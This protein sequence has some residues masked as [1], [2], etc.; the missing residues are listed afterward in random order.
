MKNIEI[1]E[2][3]KKYAFESDYESDS[4][5]NLSVGL[6]EP[7]LKLLPQWQK[8]KTLKNMNIKSDIIFGN[9]NIFATITIP[10]LFKHKNINYEDMLPEEQYKFLIY[11]IHKF[12]NQ[13]DIKEFFAYPFYIHFELHKNNNLHAHFVAILKDKYVYEINAITLEKVFSRLVNG[14]KYTAKFKLI[15]N[16]HSKVLEYINK[17]NAYTPILV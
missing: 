16:N 11:I 2:K 8:S 12:Y 10:P 9:P 4:S 14:N 13:K 17:S 15:D 7:T 3:L 6:G 1:Y 5:D